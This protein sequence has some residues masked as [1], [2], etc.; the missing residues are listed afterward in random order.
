MHFNKQ[1]RTHLNFLIIAE[2][3][4]GEKEHEE[5]MLTNLKD[6]EIDLTKYLVNKNP[7]PIDQQFNIVNMDSNVNNRPTPFQTNF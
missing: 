2:C 5:E 4:R 6:L 1:A 3:E 7:T